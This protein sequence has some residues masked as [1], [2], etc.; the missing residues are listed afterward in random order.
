MPLLQ[1][2][3]QFGVEGELLLAYHRV[4]GDHHLAADAVAVRHRERLF[5]AHDAFFHRED[6]CKLHENRRFAAR[7]DG[8]WNHLLAVLG[9]REHRKAVL[10]AETHHLNGAPPS[11]LVEPALR[12]GLGILALAERRILQ[13][14][15]VVPVVEEVVA[16]YA[17]LELRAYE[18]RGVVRGAPVRRRRPFREKLLRA[19]RQTPRLVPDPV[20]HRLGRLRRRSLL[21]RPRDIRAAPQ[22]RRSNPGGNHLPYHFYLLTRAVNARRSPCREGRVRRLSRRS[23]PLPLHPPSPPSARRKPSTSSR[24][25]RTSP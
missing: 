18:D 15:A 24:P 2:P 7:R 23:S 22:R 11:L 16:V 12:L 6:A 14:R 1:P 13:E 21:H 17:V 10:L 8:K 19:W 3:A 9:A 5:G 20:V 4:A 25:P